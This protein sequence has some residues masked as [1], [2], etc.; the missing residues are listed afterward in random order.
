LLNELNSKYE[1][2]PET[3]TQSL[4]TQPK[5]LA[6]L[7][8]PSDADA[9]AQTQETQ[10][11][12]QAK[13]SVPVPLPRK[14]LIAEPERVKAKE[15][16][17]AMKEADDLAAAGKL[18]EAEDKALHAVELAEKCKFL[19]YG[20]KGAVTDSFRRSLS[21]IILTQ[22][23]DARAQADN[24]AKAG[25]LAEAEAH[26]FKAVNYVRRAYDLDSAKKGTVLATYLMGAASILEMHDQ[27]YSETNE[28][29]I[30]AKALREEAK[31][32]LAEA[33]EALGIAAT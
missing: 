30:E 22:A 24:L 9:S 2:H 32:L 8:L 20:L 4:D 23:R 29:I 6:P 31:A 25:N 21:R 5:A 28:K 11:A 7:P 16:Q 17:N 33:R 3:A 1:L 26:M 27:T 15:A 19:G 14:K 12:T 10:P 13:A 18:V